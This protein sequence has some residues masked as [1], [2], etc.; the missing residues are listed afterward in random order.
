MKKLLFLASAGL[1]GLA[2]AGISGEHVPGEV[3]VKFKPGM[4]VVRQAALQQVGGT[5]VNENTAIGTILVRLPA[6]KSAEQGINQFRSLSAVQYAEPNYIYRAAFTPNDPSYSSLQWAPQKIEC[7]AAWDISRGDAGTVISII[8]T[9]VQLDHPDL[10]GKTL[11]GRDFVNGDND[12]TD[13][14]GHGTHCAGN[15]AA[16]TNNGVG[17]AGIGF[18]CRIL[19]VKVLSGGGGGTL[20][21]VNSGITWSADAGA[22]I[23]SLSLGGPSPSQAMEDALRYAFNRNCTILAAAGNNGVST[24]FYPAGYDQYVIAVGA[25]D[26]NDARAGYSNFGSDWVDVAAPG[27]LGQ[28][29][30]PQQEIYAT[31]IGGGYTAI[32]GTSMA[33]PVAAGVAGL[34][35]SILGTGATN[36]QIRSILESTCDPVANWTAHGR[37][38]A[39]RAADLAS[40]Q[41]QPPMDVL[42]RTL[43]MITG[44][45]AIGSAQEIGHSDNIYYVVNSVMSGSLGQVSEYQ[46]N[47]I[48]PAG[49]ITQVTLNA[50]TSGVYGGTGMIYLWNF[51]QNRWVLVRSFA[52][53][54][55][56]TTM[57]YRP[58]PLSSYLRGGEMRVR[59]RGLLPF[60]RSN[61]GPLPSPQPYGFKTDKLTAQIRMQ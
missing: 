53:N 21:W 26:R 46:A 54:S 30:N 9:G 1:P 17:I 40:Q 27:G 23:L 49:N 5:V 7:P 57:T 48:L 59:M 13:D 18:N 51:S 28:G 11:Q 36:A 45:G 6:G 8:D 56:D 42:P 31:W 10:I 41:V 55:F 60:R 35:R 61:L 3:I 2:I 50:E 32:F 15:A 38:N 24:R 44:S 29:S 37:V 20:D 33:C 4:S 47:F 12:P 39:R 58:S 52:M 14:N 25:S 34:I 22:H 43:N 19:P 16:N